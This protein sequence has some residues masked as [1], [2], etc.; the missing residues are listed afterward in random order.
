MNKVF[1]NKNLLSY[2]FQFLDPRT[3]C[4]CTQVN[5]HWYKYAVSDFVW[6]RHK[7]RIED[8]FSVR[9]MGV[10]SIYKQDCLLFRVDF[11][12]M[13]NLFLIQEIYALQI[14]TQYWGSLAM[15]PYSMSSDNSSVV[16]YGN[17]EIACIMVYARK[18]N[19]RIQME[20]LDWDVRRNRVLKSYYDV[21]L[22][23]R[24]EHDIICPKWLTI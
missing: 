5:T 16:L 6:K 3:L 19:V 4:Y 18:G 10:K 17:G 14:P 8:T 1:Q 21:I 2:I 7:D 22:D 24:N 23:V 9:F 15:E 20:Y 13:D 12:D 11:L